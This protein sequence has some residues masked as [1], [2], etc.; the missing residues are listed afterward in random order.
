MVRRG[1]WTVL[2]TRVANVRIRAVTRRLRQ[3]SAV[4]PVRVLKGIVAGLRSMKIDVTPALDLIGLTQERLHTVEDDIPRVQLRAFWDAV[5]K[6]TGQS[7][8]GLRLAELVRPEDY[9]LFGNLIASSATLGEAA[10]RAT[11]LIRLA[12]NT[13]RL[14]F[15][16]DGEQVTLSIEPLHALMHREGIEFMVAAM[17]VI[18]QKIAGRSLQP[19]E[20]RFMHPPPPDLTHHH[21]LFGARVV[22]ESSSNGIVFDGALLDLPVQSRDPGLSAE[23]QRQAE[24][25]LG[26]KPNRDF[27]AEVRAAV[28]IEVRGGNPS[29]ERVAASLAMHPKTL[30]RR[31]R[32]EGTTFRRLLDGV[33]LE[34]AERYLR[35]PGLSVEEVA[36]LLGYSE[37][38]AFHRA[39]RRWTG[40]TPRIASS[41]EP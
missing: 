24:A 33:R 11:R 7:G 12:T 32:T 29:A 31:L 3:V 40:R 27:K 34:L 26:A 35:Q 9:E 16:H 37:S 5:V 17:G 22:F 6:S 23:L 4:V 8:L 2:A 10:L 25:L 39:F 13:I 1:E 19:I 36:Y 18:S 30:N 15:E 14:S 21:R 38:S 20:V 28:A 41:P